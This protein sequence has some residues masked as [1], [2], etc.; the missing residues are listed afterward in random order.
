MNRKKNDHHMHVW[1]YTKVCFIKTVRMCYKNMGKPDQ[2]CYYPLTFSRSVL[3][4]KKID[5][6]VQKS[7][8]QHWTSI[9]TYKKKSFSKINIDL[10]KHEKLIEIKQNFVI[11]R[12]NPKKK[13][14]LNV[15]D[16]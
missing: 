13:V 11:I 4:P 2:I 7:T 10:N 12:N 8:N 16:A 9:N 1:V 14:M 3:F 6:S 5:K 15:T